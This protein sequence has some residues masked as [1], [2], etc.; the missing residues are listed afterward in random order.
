[1]TTD[2]WSGS[3]FSGRKSETGGRAMGGGV[4]RKL[5]HGFP[6]GHG[7]AGLLNG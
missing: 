3:V 5:G 2:A 1:M 4:D 7:E 6:E